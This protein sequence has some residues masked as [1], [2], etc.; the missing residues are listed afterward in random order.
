MTLNLAVIGLG[1]GGKSALLHTLENYGVS[2]C[3][4]DEKSDVLLCAGR[5]YGN[6]PKCAVAVASE[7][8][9]ETL[10]RLRDMGCTV[11]TCG[12]AP[13][14]TLSLSHIGEN[15]AAVSLQRSLVSLGGRRFEPCEIPVKLSG[16][17]DSGI[18]SAAVAVLLLCGVSA[19]KGFLLA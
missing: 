15:T 2:A 13:T 12:T 8:G 6:L 1:A 4:A 19:D 17:T 7:C 5:V 18:V 16:K 10:G 9:S 11:I 14:D 3:R